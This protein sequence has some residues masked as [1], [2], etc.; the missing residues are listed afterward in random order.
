MN[1]YFIGGFI[2]SI[3]VEL[4]FGIIKRI[5]NWF[6]KRQEFELFKW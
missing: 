6:K 2:I 1:E 5:I 3:L 4:K